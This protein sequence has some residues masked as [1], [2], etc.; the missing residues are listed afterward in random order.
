MGGDIEIDYNQVK[1]NLD[2]VDKVKEFATVSQMVE[3]ST[4][5]STTKNKNN[6][7]SFTRIKAVDQNYPLYGEVIY[8]P[9]GSLENLN[10]IDNTIIVNEN[11]FKNLKLKINDIVKVQNKEF[12]VI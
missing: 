9:I 11:I 5:I 10:K 7:T 1:G 8:E 3:F 2:L 6:K 4:M 12:K